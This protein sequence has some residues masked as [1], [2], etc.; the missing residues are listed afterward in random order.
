MIFSRPSHADLSGSQSRFQGGFYHVQDFVQRSV[1]RLFFHFLLGGGEN[2]ASGRGPLPPSDLKCEY[3]VD[4]EGI[5]VQ[6]PRFFWIRAH[7][8]RGQNRPPIRS[9]SRPTRMRERRHVGQ[10]QGCFDRVHQSSTRETPGERRDLLL[11]GPL[12]GQGRNSRVLTARSPDSAR[13]FVQGGMER[14]VDR[15][16]EPAPEG[17]RARRIPSSGQKSI[18]AGSAITSCGSTAKRSGTHVLDPGWT[19]YDKRALYVAYDVTAAPSR[20]PTRSA[21]CSATAGSRPGPCSSRS[22]SSSAGGERSSVVQRRKLEGRRRPDRRR[23][24]STTAKPTTPGSKQPGWDRPGFDDKAW[25]KAG[26]GAGPKGVLSAQMM[27]PIQDHGHDRPAQ[28]D[29][30]EARRLCLRHGPEL[31]RLGPAPRPRAARGRPSGCAS[32]RCSTTT[33]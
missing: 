20:A 16:R 14:E 1:L 33:A 12:L 4:P 29:E 23:T 27:P 13:A 8:E 24:A 3:A 7:S 25:K 2:R 11:E 17:I 19:T 15:R 26:A 6:R 31:Q 30:S 18:S 28:D 21:S 10:R 32:P 9:S 22:R 5:D